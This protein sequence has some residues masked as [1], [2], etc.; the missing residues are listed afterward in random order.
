MVVKQKYEFLPYVDSEL[1]YLLEWGSILGKYR[2]LIFINLLFIKYL[3][4]VA[5]SLGKMIASPLFFFQNAIRY[6][7]STIFDNRL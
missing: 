7:N 5:I 6:E 2:F 4:T 1:V 3:N